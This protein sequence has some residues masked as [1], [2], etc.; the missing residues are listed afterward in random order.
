MHLEHESSAL[1]SSRQGDA[2]VILLDRHA[3][4]MTTHALSTCKSLTRIGS[5][6]TP[7]QTKS[8]LIMQCY[9]SRNSISS[10][11]S[12]P[13]FS[14]CSWTG[15]KGYNGWWIG[16]SS[17]CVF[18]W[19]TELFFKKFLPFI[20]AA[21]AV[22][23]TKPRYIQDRP[24]RDPVG[25]RLGESTHRRTH[26]HVPKF[27]KGCIIV[28]LSKQLVLERLVCHQIVASSLIWI[29]SYVTWIQIYFNN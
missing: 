13:T 18:I 15:I 2:C 7:N 1:D 5:W 19:Q 29:E 16:G 14:V 24:D 27:Y 26:C 8:Y 3:W 23:H 25:D 17:L 20:R 10:T 28:H 11:E 6:H 21:C 22:K 4:C 9:L 12:V